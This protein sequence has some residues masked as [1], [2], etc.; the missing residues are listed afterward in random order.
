M[1][2]NQLDC[3]P[4]SGVMAIHATLNFCA[5]IHS[6]LFRCLCLSFLSMACAFFVFVF[7]W[8]GCYS[9]SYNVGVVAA[10]AHKLII[11]LNLFVI[12]SWLC[13]NLYVWKACNDSVDI[14][15]SSDGGNNSS[16]QNENK[17]KHCHLI[18]RYC[19]PTLNRMKQSNGKCKA[20]VFFFFLRYLLPVHVTI[21]F[22]FWSGKRNNS[23]RGNNNNTTNDQQTN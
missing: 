15:S 5:H 6:I 18:T 16:K 3:L 12:W 9:P 17:R 23:S 21:R 13:R 11:S 7:F 2:Q 8:S 19:W 14:A 20:S 1:V 4:F 22:W 10:S